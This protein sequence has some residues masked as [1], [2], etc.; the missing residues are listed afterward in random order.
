MLLALIKKPPNGP[1]EELDTVLDRTSSV[2]GVR[3]VLDIG[4]PERKLAEP[5]APQHN[6]GEA[7]NT[8]NG[9]RTFDVQQER[10]TQGNVRDRVGRRTTR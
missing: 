10:P 7:E 9:R 5:R 1:F 4:E 8:S 2:T 3:L 6:T